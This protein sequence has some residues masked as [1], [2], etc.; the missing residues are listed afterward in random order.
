MGEHFP[1]AVFGIHR[2]GIN[3]HHYCLRAEETGRFV[4]QIGIGHRRGVDAGLIG[5]GV[6]QAAHIG[7]AAH[8]A[9]DGERNKHLCGHFFNHMQYGVAVI[10]RRGDVEKG[11]FVR[12]FIV[13]ALGHVHRIARIAQADKVYPFDHPAVFYIQTGNDAFCQCHKTL[14]LT[15]AG[16]KV[17]TGLQKSALYRHYIVHQ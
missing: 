12:P 15:Q 11:E 10:R 2:L 1:A 6:E 5:S 8:A 9:A 7:Y 14:Q 17:S 13:V 4:H 3:R 16:R